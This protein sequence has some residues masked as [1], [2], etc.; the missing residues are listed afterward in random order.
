MT[1]R[2]PLVMIGGQAQ[3]LPALDVVN[4]STWTNLVLKNSWAA[5]GTP[6]AT[7][8]VRI[9]YQGEVKFRGAIKNGVT[10]TVA[11]TLG[12]MFRPTTQIYAPLAQRGL[13]SGLLG[14]GALTSAFAAIAPDGD[15]IIFCGLSQLIDL[16]ALFFPSN[17]VS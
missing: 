4:N 10:N 11:F 16:S 14:T 8:G 2:K 9:D 1:I 5:Y 13:V 6:W 3:Q 7:P 12:S 15:C 17:Q